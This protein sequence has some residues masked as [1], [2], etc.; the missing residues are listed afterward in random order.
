[1]TPFEL[2]ELLKDDL[3]LNHGALQAKTLFFKKGVCL[4]PEPFYETSVLWEEETSIREIKDAL[5]TFKKHR[6]KINEIY[7]VSQPVLEYS[8][9]RPVLI[10]STF[11]SRDPET[12]IYD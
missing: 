3:I 11:L 1:M 12:G 10:W 2:N 7:Y 9:G 8:L 5:N 4:M 6:E